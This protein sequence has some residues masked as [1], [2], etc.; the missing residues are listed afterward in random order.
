MESHG[1]AAYLLRMNRQ[2][3]SRVEKTTLVRKPV[4]S[5]KNKHQHA[6]YAS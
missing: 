2:K 6:F 3:K 5:S 4:N 1:K